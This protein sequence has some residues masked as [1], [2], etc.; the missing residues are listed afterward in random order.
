M[1]TVCAEHVVGIARYL[2]A[3]D[4]AALRC[5]SKKLKH[6]VDDAILAGPCS[7]YM[8]D[9]E[10]VAAKNA[11]GFVSW[12]RAHCLAIALRAACEK[13]R[14]IAYFINSLLGKSAYD[15]VCSI[16]M[17]FETREDV[18]CTIV[19]TYGRERPWSENI[20]PHNCEDA[21]GYASVILRMELPEGSL[22]FEFDVG[23]PAWTL[24][25]KIGNVELR[26][27]GDHVSK[28]SFHSLS[29]CYI[30]VKDFLF[31]GDYLTLMSTLDLARL[32]LLHEGYT[33]RRRSNSKQFITRVCNILEISL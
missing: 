1:D 8:T 17:H 27:A 4:V 18:T 11:V 22:E 13:S 20:E 30:D 19:D 26:T 23:Y 14:D 6:T 12:S 29:R 16:G 33:L 31:W 25:W 21:D 7:P 15:C 9:A 2:R 24:T 5:V 3:R 28:V 10:L 32:A